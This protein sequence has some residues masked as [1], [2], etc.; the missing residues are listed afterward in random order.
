MDP[1]PPVIVKAFEHSQDRRRRTA[2]C[3]GAAS[4][5]ET[6][7][8]HGT[9]GQAGGQGEQLPADGVV[10]LGRQAPPPPV[11]QHG[12]HA[13]DPVILRK[14]GVDGQAPAV[15][16]AHPNRLL[17][18]SDHGPGDT[19]GTIRVVLVRADAIESLNDGEDGHPDK[20]QPCG[21]RDDPAPQP[22]GGLGQ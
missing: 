3:G 14:G 8:Q 10:G 4:A 19:R 2:Q 20:N 13:A 22:D 15:V 6:G 11:L 18:P 21:D 12:H 5:Q 7:E 1:D 9:P 17:A 16:G